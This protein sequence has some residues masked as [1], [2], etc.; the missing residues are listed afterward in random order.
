[1]NA[2]GSPSALIEMYDDVHGPMP[3]MAS[4]LASSS[5]GSAP[6]SMVILPSA[7]DS[8]TATSA[9]LRPAG[10]ENTSGALA[11]SSAMAEGEGNV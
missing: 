8:A 4:S 10:I 2:S 7:T 3:E 6:G 5:S 11:P 9:L 1:M